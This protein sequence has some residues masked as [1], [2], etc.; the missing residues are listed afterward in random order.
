M[1]P[2]YISCFG[3]ASDQFKYYVDVSYLI[4]IYSSMVTVTFIFRTSTLIFR[5]LLL[6]QINAKCD[7]NFSYLIVIS[8]QC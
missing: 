3:V 5:I 7:S 6:F 8:D 2:Y 4:V 1:I